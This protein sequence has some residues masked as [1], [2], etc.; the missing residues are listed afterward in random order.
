MLSDILDYDD[1]TDN[2]NSSLMKRKNYFDSKLNV[3]A[4]KDRTKNIS[5]F[6]DSSPNDYKPP[7]KV[8]FY[9]PIIKQHNN[10]E[11]IENTQLAARRYGIKLEIPTM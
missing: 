10:F 3:L 6:F 11:L 4:K 8:P 2:L 1:Y 9:P 5:K 7:G